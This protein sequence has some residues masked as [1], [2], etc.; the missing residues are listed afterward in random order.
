[1]VPSSVGISLCKL[2]LCGESHIGTSRRDPALDTVQMALAP[3]I[4]PVQLIKCKFS[5]MSFKL[6]RSLIFFAWTLEN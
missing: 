1:M 3:V 4:Q 2:L 6:E 5:I